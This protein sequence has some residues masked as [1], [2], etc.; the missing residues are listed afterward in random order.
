M[1]A[2]QAEAAPPLS[3]GGSVRSGRAASAASPP[4]SGGGKLTD[5]PFAPACGLVCRSGSCVHLQE[6]S[7]E[8]R[9]LPRSPRRAGF[10]CHMH[11]PAGGAAAARARTNG[12]A[13]DHPAALRAA[14][15][16]TAATA[17][18]EGGEVRR[19]GPCLQWQGIVVRGSAALVLCQ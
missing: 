14:V 2:L 10:L 17:V 9:S 6:P 1:R 16:L 19:R 3:P 11:M 4:H 15:V 12:V 18:H 8:R 5:G 13:E 7:S